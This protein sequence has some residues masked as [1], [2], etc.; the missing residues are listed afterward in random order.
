MQCQGLVT[1]KSKRGRHAG[2]GGEAFRAEATTTKRYAPL[3]LLLSQ[4]CP[5][6][7]QLY[8]L[9]YVPQP[10]TQPRPPVW[11]RPCPS[12][13]R[14][15]KVFQKR[16]WVTFGQ[17]TT[18]PAPKNEARRLRNLCDTL[19]KCFTKWAGWRNTRDLPL[20]T[21][22]NGRKRSVFPGGQMRVEVGIKNL[23]RISNSSR[24]QVRKTTS[25]K[26]AEI[27]NS[28]GAL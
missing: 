25:K 3:P 9:P 28:P 14:E 18:H 11:R 15:I 19:H 4:F 23:Y 24:R 13:S 5:S 22:G 2:G 1:Y 20:A 10:S 6:P 17:C 16:V 8:T 27:S 26:G 21:V 7:V 12:S